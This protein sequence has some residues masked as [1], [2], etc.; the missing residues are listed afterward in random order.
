MGQSTEV[1]LDYAYPQAFAKIGMHDIPSE[2]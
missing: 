2:I 1:F